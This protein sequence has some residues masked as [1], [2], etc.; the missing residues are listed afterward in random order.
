VLTRRG[1]AV[2][3]AAAPVLLAA[4]LLGLPELFEVAGAMVAVVLVA[5]LGLGR[6]SSMAVAVDVEPRRP[7]AGDLLVV[8]VTVANRGSRPSPAAIA[9]AAGGAHA[10]PARGGHA[11]SFGV[12]RLRPGEQ[13]CWRVELTAGRRGDLP[14]PSWSLTVGDPLG[15]ASRL[16]ASAGGGRVRVLPRPARPGAASL[17]VGL[18][19]AEEDVRSRAD[20]LAAGASGLRPYV[21]GDDLRRV[22]WPTSARVGELMVREGGDAEA[23]QVTSLTLFLEDRRGAIGIEEFENAV[24]VAAGLVDLARATRGRRP[25]LRLVLASGTD[26][27]GPALLATPEQVEDALA[28]A[29]RRSD[30][31]PGAAFAAL[32]RCERPDLLVLC[33]GRTSGVNGLEPLSSVARAYRGVVVATG[34]APGLA[35]RARRPWPVGDQQGMP[36]P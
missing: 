5:R 14:L 29:E 12:P 4:R 19:R 7:R 2:L 27:G 17:S 13:A 36:V 9:E 28:D 18:G 32:R 31:P 6:R 23:G 1:W 34:S 24:A 11:R 26:L 20:G 22:H 35:S 3:A 33:L 25:R 16:V 8:T 30:V 10:G 21:P 15:L